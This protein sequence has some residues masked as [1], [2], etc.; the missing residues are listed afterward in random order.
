MESSFLVDYAFENSEDQ[1]NTYRISLFSAI[2]P[3]ALTNWLCLSDF[4]DIKKNR[5]NY[6]DPVELWNET[7]NIN[8]FFFFFSNSYLLSESCYAIRNKIIYGV[9]GRKIN[10]I[11]NGYF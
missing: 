5:L 1:Y 6:M 2:F 11:A 8:Y 9:L 4:R 10:T 7:A 3:N